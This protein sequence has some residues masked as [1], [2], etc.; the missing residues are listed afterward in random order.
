M[1]GTRC[2]TEESADDNCGAALDV[3]KEL[4]QIVHHGWSAISI[5]LQCFANKGTSFDDLT[6]PFE[7]YSDSEITL[8]L[9]EISYQP[10]MAESATI[11]CQ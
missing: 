7:I 8:Q 5:D 3:S 4:S 10:N 11:S 6:V 1:V 9:G 2:Q